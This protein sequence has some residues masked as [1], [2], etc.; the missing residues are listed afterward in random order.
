MRTGN[1]STQRPDRRRR[2]SGLWPAFYLT[3]WSALSG[4]E[5]VQHG[6]PPIAHESHVDAAD[7]RRLLRH[8]EVEAEKAQIAADADRSGSAEH[9][10]R[11]AVEQLLRLLV[12]RFMPAGRPVGVGPD[13]VLRVVACDRLQATLRIAF[14]EHGE[15]VRQHQL[16]DPP[17]FG[18]RGV[19][20][21][22]RRSRWV[23]TMSIT[24]STVS[25]RAQS[26]WSSTAS[27]TQVIGLA[28]AW[29][30]RS[31]PAR[32]ASSEVPPIA[33]TTG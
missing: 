29:T 24:S 5:R 20:A 9:E 10:V 16:A 17:G 33:S 26:R 4:Q 14:V 31:S 30:T 8:A 25:S 3:P 1:A 12:H 28:P 11:H 27:A 13:H 6:D 21:H 18:P 15:E 22:A 2:R 19:D 7:R 32:C 23:S